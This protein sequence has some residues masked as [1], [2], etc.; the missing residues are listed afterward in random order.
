MFTLCGWHLVVMGHF[1]P[2]WHWTGIG[3][4]V[5]L[6]LPTVLTPL[7]VRSGSFFLCGYLSHFSQ[8]LTLFLEHFSVH[9]LCQ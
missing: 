9:S 1:P 8:P 5:V 2:F 7:C 4:G 6:L 3:A